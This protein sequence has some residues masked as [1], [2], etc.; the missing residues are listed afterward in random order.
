[1]GSCICTNDVLTPTQFHERSAKNVP[2]LMPKEKPAPPPEPVKERIIFGQKPDKTK[3]RR[4][5]KKV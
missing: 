5:P 4:P 3:K 1:M 2:K